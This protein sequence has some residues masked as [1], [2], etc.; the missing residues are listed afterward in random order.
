MSLPA[1]PT[2]IPCIMP[3]STNPSRLMPAPEFNR[4]AHTNAKRVHM[5]HPIH[6]IRFLD[7]HFPLHAR[8]SVAMDVLPTHEILVRAPLSIAGKR[9]LGSGCGGLSPDIY[10]TYFPPDIHP[11]YFFRILLPVTCPEYFFRILIPEMC[12]KRS[13]SRRSTWPPAIANPM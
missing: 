6:H 11:R 8:K 2:K 12:A 7:T 3:P 9:M 1:F 13:N 5:R 4:P 10:F